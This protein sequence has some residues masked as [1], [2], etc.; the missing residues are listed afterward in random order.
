MYHTV[1]LK[2]DGTVVAWGYNAQRQTSI[3]EGLTGVVAIAAGSGHT[4]A[5]RIDGTVVAW[6]ANYGAPIPAGLT[7][8]TAI[9][10]GTYHTVALRIPGP[11][12]AAATAQVVNGFVVGGILTDGGYGYIDTPVVTISGGGGSGATAKATLV[13]GV[14]TAIT[15]LNPGSGYTSAPTITIDR[16]LVFSALRA[17]SRAVVM[18]WS[19]GTPLIFSAHAGV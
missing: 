18:I 7:G 4:V 9:A 10:A 17:N 6:G 8:V 3:P 13:D 12:S 16:P 15:L 2:S 11:R 14:V 1:A 19:R 5:L